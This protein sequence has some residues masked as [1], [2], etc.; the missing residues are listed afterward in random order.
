MRE[1]PQN[2]NM[3]RWQLNNQRPDRFRKPSK[4]AIAAAKR[5][6]REDNDEEHLAM[7]RRL[8]C[9]LGHERQSVEAH[10][11]QHGPALKHRGVGM[12]SPDRFAVPLVHWRHMELHSLGSRNERAYFEEQGI[13]PYALAEAL[14]ANRGDIARLARVLTAHQMQAS[15]KRR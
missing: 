5:A 8:W 7:I 9:T 13:D 3:P 2:L 11:L 1:R 15:L 6:A 12:K 10:H 4:R 14:W